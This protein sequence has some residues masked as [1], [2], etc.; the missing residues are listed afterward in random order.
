MKFIVKAEI[1]EGSVNSYQ[2]IAELES[3]KNANKQFIEEKT[4]ELKLQYGKL[5]NVPSEIKRKMTEM[6]RQQYGVFDTSE[7][8]TDMVDVFNNPHMRGVGNATVE[9]T[10][11][12]EYPKVYKRDH[13]LFWID[14][15][16]KTV[17][18]YGK[19]DWTRSFSFF[20]MSE[21]NT[22]SD[23][24]NAVMNEKEI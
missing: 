18:I 7:I 12:C 19:F 16:W 3:I 20:G 13:L 6:T 1:I 2:R 10:P 21:N 4:K 11:L 22:E 17:R 5:H 15:K 23:I 14:Y 9:I 24:V 8:N